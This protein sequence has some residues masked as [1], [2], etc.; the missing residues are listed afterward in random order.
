HAGVALRVRRHRHRTRPPRH[1]PMGWLASFA[2]A[3]LSGGVAL[4][5]AGFVANACVTWYRVSGFEGKA[6]YAVV[7]VAL[8][9]GIAGFVIGLVT[10]RVVAASEKPGFLLALG[11]ALGVV[12]G[13]AALVLLVARLFADVPPRLGGQEMMLR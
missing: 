10:A 9:G 12:V 6:G 4:V 2:V 11:S 3:V 7:A 1:T 13:L 5:V 8:L